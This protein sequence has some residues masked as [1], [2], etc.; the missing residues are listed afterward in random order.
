MV[1]RR[2]FGWVQDAGDLF[3]LRN[4]V[5]IFV[6]DS[7]THK[8][9]LEEKIPQYISNHHG[10]DKFIFELTHEPIEIPYIDL[11]G[12]GAVEG[13]K[14]AN[15]PCTG[16][17]QAV[18]ESQ[19]KKPYVS[20]WAI[21]SYLRL[22][23]SIGFLEYHRKTDIVT[24]N[25][26]GK[27]FAATE[28][29]SEEE[30]EILA[31]ALL[32]YPP[33]TRI[34]SI[35][36]ENPNGLT[37]YGLG[38]QL[39]FVG[40]NGFSS[41]PEK[42]VF[43]ALA[44]AN[45]AE[46]K[47]IKSNAEG[48]A[49]KYARTI[50]GWLSQLGWLKKQSVIKTFHLSSGLTYTCK[51]TIFSLTLQGKQALTKSRGLSKHNHIPKIV[52][53]EMLATKAFELENVRRRRAY[54]LDSLMKGKQ[55]IDGILDRLD[56][57]NVFATESLIADD[58]QGLI[59]IGLRI[60][61]S[62]GY[63]YL[64]DEII[65]L[66]IPPNEQVDDIGSS[67]EQLKDT[68][69]KHLHSINHKYLSLIDYSYDKDA[70]LAFEMA[71]IQLLHEELG[72][73]AIHLGYANRPDGVLSI[74]NHGVII[75]NK[76][77]KDGFSLNSA[78]RREMKDYIE[79]NQIRNP[80]LYQ[81]QWWE[82]FEKDVTDFSYL[83]VSSFFTGN[84]RHSMAKLKEETNTSGA[85]INAENLL[86]LADLIKTSRIDETELINLLKSDGEIVIERPS[87]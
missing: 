57:A 32:S 10:R 22:A 25:E 15:A 85:V 13:T 30:K 61:E 33:A 65:K 78:S 6:K 60:R 53:Y 18:I 14:R 79:Q 3:K 20:D 54:L 81:N 71:T 37:K 40:E 39:G 27:K 74:L 23:I 36:D 24:L 4:I 1:K 83:F 42:L 31:T 55:S 80:S 29:G 50:A 17:A 67:F 70:F 52:M 11:K 8:L 56:G 28:K 84:F 5:E 76:S 62:D 64:D 63:Y 41:F 46:R 86:Y 9:L 21:D 59:N 77:Y 43:E 49:D 69:R 7:P 12:K 58:V 66:S 35:L 26:L 44:T 48:T 16:I 2:S 19:Q 73:K 34:L 87:L 51:T 68:I 38:Q 72:L 45:K 82:N 75:D 47:K